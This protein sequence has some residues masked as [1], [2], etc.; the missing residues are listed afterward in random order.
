MTRITISLS[1]DLAVVLA[2][3]ARRRGEPVSV[4]VRRALHEHLHN[5]A[6]SRR[7]LPFVAL[8]RSG[9]KHTGRDAEKILAR[10]WARDRRR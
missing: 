9:R 2:R 4:V 5:T 6:G 10:E 7:E 3:E 8:G 1:D